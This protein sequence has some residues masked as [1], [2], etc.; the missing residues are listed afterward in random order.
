MKK[1]INHVNVSL[2]PLKL[3]ARIPD[4]KIFI[5]LNRSIRDLLKL[6]IIDSCLSY[7]PNPKEESFFINGKGTYA[8]DITST[9]ISYVVGIYTHKSF[10]RSD[11]IYVDQPPPEEVRIHEIIYKH[12]NARII[13]H[14]YDDKHKIRC[15]KTSFFPLWSKELADNVFRAIKRYRSNKKS[16][17]VYPKLIHMQKNGYLLIGKNIED[18]K[19]IYTHKF[20]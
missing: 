3:N 6:N 10:E 11:L 17:T 19:R 15:P 7:R 18:I 4:K 5:D 1:K 9:D 14:I 8:G 2:H 13:L 12:T 16:K 20:L